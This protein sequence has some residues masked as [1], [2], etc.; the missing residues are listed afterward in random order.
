MIRSHFAVT[1]LLLLPFGLL[2]ALYLA[3]VG[4]GGA[5]LYLQMRAVETRLLVAEI[6]AAVGPLAE[7]LGGVDALTALEAAEP[8]LA[9][10]L[11]RLFI[12]LP[13]LKT[14]TL[15]DGQRGFALQPDG[16][17]SE[18]PPFTAPLATHAEP[19]STD[20]PAAQRLFSESEDEF[21]LGYDLTSEA[22]APTR[23]AL[24]FDRE[25]LQ[26]HIGAG[27]ASIERAIRLLA[28]VGA[29]SIVAAFGIAFFAMHRTRHIEAHF[30][31]IYRR[32][33]ITELAA[34]LVHELRNPLMALRAN[35]T[36]LQVAP[37]QS[38]D[39][40]ADLER[41]IVA[42]STKLS[43]FLKLTRRPEDTFTAID[44]EPM[45]QEAVRL[46]GPILAERGLD[47]MI[48]IPADM[49]QAV[50]QRE[51]MRDAL[52]N[53]LINAAQS[54][55]TEGAISVSTR[56]ADGWL[57][58]V[59][60]DRGQGIA[61]EHAP[62]LFDAF[63]TTKPDGNGLGLAIVQRVVADHGGQVRAENRAGGGARILLSVPLRRNEVPHWWKALRRRPL[64]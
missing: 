42:L 2:L 50:L 6:D 55:Q 31:D 32:A 19:P 13:S 17:W 18:Q 64:T 35:V 59:V 34:E 27:L 61:E 28:G 62:R 26:A 48:D 23:L 10:D 20:P 22:A 36:A 54:G 56:V 60:E 44:V 5:W 39:I 47:V 21:R 37:E 3:V 45:L 29:L 51:A 11:T 8:W 43:A 41:D 7:K 57:Q 24:T 58:I 53:I 16:A 25:R 52:V 14:I 38:Q 1:R 63:Y 30:Q 40:V 9:G 12:D 4:G 46:A 49:P 33:S 15:R